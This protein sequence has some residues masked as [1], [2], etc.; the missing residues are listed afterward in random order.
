MNEPVGDIYER[1][2]RNIQVSHLNENDE[3][4]T[5]EEAEAILN[6]FS[7]IKALQA[8]AF[9]VEEELKIAISS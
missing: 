6:D 3:H 5:R 2:L 9:A 1:L 8:F 7:I 4:P